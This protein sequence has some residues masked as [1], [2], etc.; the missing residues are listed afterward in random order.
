MSRVLSCLFVAA[1]GAVL[2]S[3]GTP[4]VTAP[5]AMAAYEPPGAIERAPLAPPPGYGP[6]PSAPT[7][8][9]PQ[10]A[11]PGGGTPDAGSASQGAGNLTWKASPRWA[12][13]RGNDKL[14]GEQAN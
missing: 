13:V 1:A 3:C 2:A 11:G 8:I 4:Q 7:S 6:A 10:V 9:L 5:A 14:V 12:E